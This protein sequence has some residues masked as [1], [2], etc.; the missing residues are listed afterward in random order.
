LEFSVIIYEKVLK[1]V[2]ACPFF[3]VMATRTAWFLPKNYGF[4][5]LPN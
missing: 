3:T 1:K 2:L 5:A 4:E